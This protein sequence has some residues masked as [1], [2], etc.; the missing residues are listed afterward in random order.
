MLVQSLGQH[1]TNVTVLSITL[2]RDFG[3]VATDYSSANASNSYWFDSNMNMTRI[4]SL[5]V[6]SNGPYNLIVIATGLS[7]Q[8]KGIVLDTD[9]S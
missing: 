4:S 8:V 6:S 2:P 3:Y 7:Q 9:I 5:T 1:E